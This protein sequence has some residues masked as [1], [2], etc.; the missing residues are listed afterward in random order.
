[1]AKRTKIAAPQ[2]P[3]PQSDAQAAAAIARIGELM[4]D[5]DRIKATGDDRIAAIAAEVAEQSAPLREMVKAETEGL[6]VYCEANRNR[7]TDMFRRKST[8]FETGCVGW[9]DR[10][11]KVTLRDKAEEI[12]A[13]VKALGLGRFVRVKEEID[14]EAMLREPAIARSIVGV[15]IGSA[16]EDFYVEPLE[17]AEAAAS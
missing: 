16:G 3:V 12:I 6:K 17:M 7:L 14:K 5:L 2:L 15:S 1:M 8:K 11:A 10:P 13:R 9:R 4:R